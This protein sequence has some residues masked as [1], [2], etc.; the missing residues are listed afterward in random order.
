M[1]NENNGLKIF[2][3]CLKKEKVNN[4]QLVL[5]VEYCGMYPECSSFGYML[6]LPT[7]VLLYRLMMMIG[8]GGEY[9]GW[10]EEFSLL[11]K[12]S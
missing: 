12:L 2:L 8:E 11:L 9:N 3:W 7:S 1:G 5:W 10:M 6:S 4:I